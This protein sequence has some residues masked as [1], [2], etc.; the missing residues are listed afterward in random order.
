MEIDQKIEYALNLSDLDQQYIFEEYSKLASLCNEI[1]LLKE[2]HIEGSLKLV[3][4]F[5]NAI[6]E[7]YQKRGDFRAELESYPSTKEWVKNL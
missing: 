7:F 5:K 1:F 2:N 4:E 6:K 3:E